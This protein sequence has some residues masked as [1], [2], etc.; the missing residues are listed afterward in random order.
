[1][2]TLLH[3]YKNRLL[4]KTNCGVSL[5]TLV[6]NCVC[7]NTELSHGGLILVVCCSQ[8]SLFCQQLQQLVEHHLEGFPFLMEKTWLYVM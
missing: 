4:S 1:M 5:I 6:I 7:C 8:N 2:L 3:Y